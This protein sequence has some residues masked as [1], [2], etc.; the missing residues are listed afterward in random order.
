MNIRQNLIIAGVVVGVMW[1]VFVI[2]LILP[3]SLTQFGIRPRRLDGLWGLIFSPF[4]HANLRHIMANTGAVFILL[5]LS[6][7]FSRIYTVEAV[8]LIAGV[9][10]GLVWLFGRSGTV[11]V[12][13]SGIIFGLIGFL[14]FAG[15]FL[16]D[17]KSLL[18]SVVVLFLYGGVILIGFVPMPGVSWTGHV[19]GFLSGVLAAWLAGSAKKA[20]ETG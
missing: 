2:D 20:E 19:F 3:V 18:V 4:L 11:H 1:G 9:G 12:G 15:V 7:S 10:G 14:L 16:R 8:I 17:L 13:A 6:L 5:T